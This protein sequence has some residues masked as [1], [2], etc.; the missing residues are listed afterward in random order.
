MRR[1]YPL[2]ICDDGVARLVKDRQVTS[3]L[4]QLTLPLELNRPYRLS[5]TVRGNRVVAEI[6]G[7]IVADVVDENDPLMVGRVG[8]I[9]REGTLSS[10]ALRVEPIA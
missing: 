4:A 10:G 2:L 1:W 6:D 5:L 8:L 7:Q 9:V 3:V